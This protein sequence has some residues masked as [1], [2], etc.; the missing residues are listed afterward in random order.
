MDVR[1]P[2][3]DGPETL[4]ALRAINPQIQCCFM[5]GDLGGHTRPGLLGLGA[6]AVLEK[7]FTLDDVTH[8][9]RA[10]VSGSSLSPGVL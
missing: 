8:A 2:G 10:L 6:A 4:A 7:P 5:S 3:L 9:L 1:M